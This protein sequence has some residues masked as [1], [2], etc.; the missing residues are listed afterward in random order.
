MKSSIRPNGISV[1]LILDLILDSITLKRNNIPL[2]LL[3]SKTAKL[4]MHSQGFPGR[5]G[6]L[7]GWV[8]ADQT[9]DVTLVNLMK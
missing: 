3:F 6:T 5:V 8:T 7:L 4:L 9:C 2:G 1:T